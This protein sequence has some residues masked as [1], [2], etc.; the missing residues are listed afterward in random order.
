MQRFFI[1]LGTMDGANSGEL[2]KFVANATGVSGRDIGRIET[3]EKFAFLEAPAHLTDTIMGIKGEMFGSRRVSIELATA[4]TGGR[5][6]GG[7][8]GYRGG[9]RGGSSGG[10]SY[11]SRGGSAGAPSR[12]RY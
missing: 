8:G 5:A 11:G 12:N 3:K 2:L 9:S 10:R 7:G 4:P 6:F 1:N